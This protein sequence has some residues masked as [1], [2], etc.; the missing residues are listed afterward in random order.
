VRQTFLS[1]I[2]KGD[3][4]LASMFS[5]EARAVRN[6]C[7]TIFCSLALTA[8]DPRTTNAAT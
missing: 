4:Q 7:P 2:A 1:A 6:V 8:I 5:M 3:S